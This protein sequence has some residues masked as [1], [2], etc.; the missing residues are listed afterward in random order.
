[1]FDE[2]TLTNIYSW[3]PS[4]TLPH[5]TKL[6]TTHDFENIEM[7]DQTPHMDITTSALTVPPPTSASPHA[8]EESSGWTKNKA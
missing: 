5:P 6:F 1:M 8:S 4:S 3:G 7:E 2:E